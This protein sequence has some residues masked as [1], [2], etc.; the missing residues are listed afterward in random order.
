MCECSGKSSLG[1]YLGLVGSQVGDRVTDKAMV[2]RK[3]IKDWTGLGDYKINYNSL[4]ESSMQEPKLFQSRGRGLII[5]HREYLGDIVT[6]ST[7]I[8]AFSVNKY[9]INPG[10]V[11]TF[12]WLS[13]IAGQH[14]Q[15]APRGIIFEFVST[16]S[17]TSTSASLGSVLFSTQY[18]VT[19]SDPSSKS[20][21][22]NRDYANETKMSQSAIHGLECDPGEL[23]RTILYTRAYGS[24]VSDPRDFDMANFY[25][26]TQGGSLPISTIVGS[27]Y[28]HY[29]FE[30]F[31]QVPSG[32]IPNLTQLWQTNVGSA[33]GAVTPTFAVFLPVI[34]QGRNLG[35]TFTSA[36]TITIPK[37]WQGATFLITAQL[38]MGGGAVTVANVITYTN[39]TAILSPFGNWRQAPATGSTSSFINTTYLVRINSNIATDA[40]ISAGGSPF[41]FPALTPVG[42]SSMTIECE[43]VSKN[44]N[45]IS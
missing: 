3:R 13:P 38:V 40:I 43:V 16:A 10:N 25:V 26:G 5:K 28:V 11:I 29:E 6:S 36:G 17:E 22:M 20:D 7:A 18:D 2:L 12:P 27:L 8:G 42:G 24:S 37:A 30:F 39:C 35:I 41:N 32:G 14:D 33:N 44:Y 15:Y 45:L 34:T 31:K 19:D 21:M 4:I 1:N 9:T 23:Q